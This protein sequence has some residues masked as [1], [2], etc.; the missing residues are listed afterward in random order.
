[1]LALQ[2]GKTT[3]ENLRRHIT[4]TFIPAAEGKDDR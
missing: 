3:Y 2:D 1:M 4:Y